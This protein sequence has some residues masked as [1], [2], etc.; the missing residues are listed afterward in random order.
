M[1][2]G[3]LRE[4]SRD[5][6]RG[7][8]RRPQAAASAL[9]V[10]ALASGLGSLCVWVESGAFWPEAIPPHVQYLGEDYHCEDLGTPDLAGLTLQGHT[11]G[12]GLIYA[13]PPIGSEAS[14]GFVVVTDGYRHQT[15][16]F[17]GP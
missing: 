6:S 5:G 1:T 16:I 17:A 15:C 12:G 14:E 4:A 9:A 11:I 7:W 8:W 2:S 10:A 13:R 3:L